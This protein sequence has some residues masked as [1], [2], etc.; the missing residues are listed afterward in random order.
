LDFN[1]LQKISKNGLLPLQK[2]REDKTRLDFYYFRRL[3]KTGEDFFEFQKRSKNKLK[4]ELNH[5]REENQFHPHH[6][7]KICR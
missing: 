4:L 1:Q 2:R 6:S 5:S 7:W 3:E